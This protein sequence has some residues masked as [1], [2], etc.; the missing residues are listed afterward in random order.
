MF[1]FRPKHFGSIAFQVFNNFVNPELRIAFDQQMYMVRHDFHLDD[2]RPQLFHFFK[3]QLFQSAVD[4]RNEHLAA[5]LRTE[6]D[7]IFAIKR[8]VVIAIYCSW[9][10][11]HPKN[12]IAKNIRYFKL[13]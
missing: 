10:W 2:L 6:Y 8:Y 5:I 3:K 11:I 13:V 12:S 7:V 1:E 4:R 9:H